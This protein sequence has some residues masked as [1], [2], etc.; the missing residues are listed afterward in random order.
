MQINDILEVKIEKMLYEGKALAR[1]ENFPI[2]IE[3]ACTDDILKVKIEKVNK[4]Y[5]IASI[6]EIIKPSE[7]RITPLCSMHNVCGSCNWQYIKYDRQLIEKQNI[8]YE[9]IK[10]IAGMELSVNQTVKSPKTTEYRCKIQY[11]VSQTK[12]SKRIL[13]GYYKKNSHELINI[14][15][16]PMQDKR[17]SE[18][19]E[20]IRVEAQKLNIA[21]YDE[22][23][24]KGLLRHIIFRESSD[25]K[26][27][28]VIFVINSNKIANEI[29]KLAEITASNF[30]E[31]VGVCANFNTKKSNVIMGSETTEITGDDYYIENLS[32]NQYKVSANSFFQVNPYCAELIFNET[33]KFIEATFKD[34][35]TVLDAYSGVSSFGI[36]VSPVAKKVISI[37]EVEQATQNAKYNKKLNNVTNLEIMTGDAAINFEKLISNGTKF[38]VSLIDP[39]RKGCSEE[40][41]NYAMK[42]TK[43]TIIY[44]S[45]NPATLARDLKYLISNGCK[46][47]YIQPFDMF[48]HTYHVEC[49]AIIKNHK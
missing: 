9:T 46:V 33:K 7:Y 18:M 5:A 47:E 1:V 2:F 44:V 13:A 38:D 12:V 6:V 28:L 41:L 25:F 27:V 37:E 32:G 45:C 8:V 40:S 31:I 20:F 17:I 29:K 48:P 24:H 30:K 19:L 23:S 39:P 21:A 3:N 16:C 49:V 11:P 36:W 35:P 10:H 15:Y 14:K 4:N 42:L 26:S 34:K 22:K 43:D